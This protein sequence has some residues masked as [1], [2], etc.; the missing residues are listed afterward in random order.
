MNKTIAAVVVTY[1]RKTLLTECL[2]ALLRQTRPVD[3]IILIDNDSTDGTKSLLSEKGY[4]KDPIIEYVRLPENTG[5][6]GGFHEGVK[7]GYEGKY[8][9]LWLMDDDAEPKPDSL[10]QL[11]LFLQMR[12]NDD[13]VMVT[14]KNV[15]ISGQI[16]KSHRG[17][18]DI[19]KLEIVPLRDED[20][21]KH[22]CEI[23]FSSF[24]GPLFSRKVVKKI[25]F[26][27]KDLFIWCDDLEYSIRA[28]KYGKMYVV[29]DSIILHKDNSE[30]QSR[31]YL[32]IDQYWKMYYGRRNRI[33]LL[34]KHFGTNNLRIFLYEM[35]NPIRHVL[36]KEPQK[37]K[38]IQLLIKAYVD[39]YSGNMGKTI[40]P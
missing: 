35:L 21:G 19:N 30:H 34:R 17:F 27:D 38:R 10:Q 25:G 29:N 26:P 20:Y 40:I 11:M 4:L 7:L 15:G 39:A 5:G 12:N 2:D 18:F 24:V 6:A 14:P 3:K 37:I 22:C 1:N 33:Y 13:I 9:W 8:D 23:G 32:P 16:Q 28:K 36:F 31:K